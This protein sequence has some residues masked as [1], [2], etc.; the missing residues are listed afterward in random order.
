MRCAIVSPNKTSK[1]VRGCLAA[2][3]T[4]GTLLLC[5]GMALAFSYDDLILLVQAEQKQG[6]SK[7]NLSLDERLRNLETSVFGAAR[8]GSESKRLKDVC[9]QIGL[10]HDAPPP[11]QPNAEEKGPKGIGKPV[12]GSATPQPARVETA[13]PTPVTPPKPP[14][15]KPPARVETPKNVATE[16]P[17]VKPVE[18]PRKPPAPKPPKFE[19]PDNITKPPVNTQPPKVEETPP[20]P[21]VQPQADPQPST[22]TTTETPPQN[23]EPIVPGETGASTSRTGSAAGLV[24]VGLLG[25]IGFLVFGAVGVVVFLFVKEKSKATKEQHKFDS[26]DGNEPTRQPE[27]AKS[28][29]S[30]SVT[31]QITWDESPAEERP[32]AKS[33]EVEEPADESLLSVKN[34]VFKISVA[35]TQ[36]TL[37]PIA[38]GEIDNPLAYQDGAQPEARS[39]EPP[40]SVQPLFE[41]SAGAVSFSDMVDAAKSFN[42]EISTVPPPA[43][44]LDPSP[45]SDAPQYSLQYQTHSDYDHNAA[46]PTP[47]GYG[48]FLNGGSS[49]AEPS[50]AWAQAAFPFSTQPQSEAGT[51]SNA[52]IS[53]ADAARPIE[54]TTDSASQDPLP[55]QSWDLDGNVIYNH[56]MPAEHSSSE[57][58][59]SEAAS[60]P[61]GHWTSGPSLE[62]SGSGVLWKA[63][64]LDQHTPAP[65][66]QIQW[67]A[68]NQTFSEMETALQRTTTGDAEPDHPYVAENNSSENDP[69]LETIQGALPSSVEPWS[70]H[71]GAE[72]QGLVQYDP[73]DMLSEHTQGH[74]ADL[75]PAPSLQG[76][77]SSY[78]DG[79][80]A[81]ESSQEEENAT[82]ENAYGANY[83]LEYINDVTG[84]DTADAPASVSNLQMHS[85]IDG[86][87]SASGDV[88]TAHSNL[89]DELP[90]ESVAQLGTPSGTTEDAEPAA[91]QMSSKND[92]IDPDSV[93]H[94][95]PGAGDSFE[96]A[97]NVPSFEEFQKNRPAS[98]ST[99]GEYGP[100]LSPLPGAMSSVF[101]PF[102][103]EINQT[104]D[105]SSASKMNSQSSNVP[106]E[107]RDF[108][109]QSMRDT[110]RGA[111]DEA[112]HAGEPVAEA[113]AAQAEPPEA[114]VP[115]VPPP[116]QDSL[117][118]ALSK[119]GL[120]PGPQ[121]SKAL[122]DIWSPQTPEQEESEQEQPQQEEPQQEYAQQ[123][124]SNEDESQQ[125]TRPDVSPSLPKSFSQMLAGILADPPGKGTALQDDAAPADDEDAAV[126][127][128][129]YD[130]EQVETAYDAGHDDSAR[131]HA[132]SLQGALNEALTG[133]YGGKKDQEDSVFE[134]LLRTLFADDDYQPELFPNLAKEGAEDN[135][136]SVPPSTPL[137]S[138]IRPSVPAPAVA[139]GAIAFAGQQ[140]MQVAPPPVQ[141]PAAEVDSPLLV[142]SN[143]GQYQN[144]LRNL[145]S[146]VSK[147]DRVRRGEYQAVIYETQPGCLILCVDQSASMKSPLHPGSSACKSDIVAVVINRF[148]HRLI[149]RC[150]QESGKIRASW[151]V[152][153]IGYGETVGPAFIG[154]HQGKE[155]VSVSDLSMT[156]DYVLPDRPKSTIVGIPVW[157]RPK[158]SGQ[159]RMC[160]ALSTALKLARDFV[161]DNPTSHPPIIVN[162]SGGTV[163]DGDP[164]PLAKGIKEI[165]SADGNVLLFNVCLPGKPDEEML[166]FPD[167]PSQLPDHLAAKAMWEMSSPLLLKMI[168]LAREYHI[169]ISPRAR[170]FA[171]N[172]DVNVIAGLLEMCT[173]ET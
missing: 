25:V 153:V 123:K 117:N 2:V 18:R 111:T 95:Q 11:E 97:E 161:A 100:T 169:E 116:A 132:P 10:L 16:E 102:V 104:V 54:Q 130:P 8:A 144:Q 156:V 136:V 143:S 26:T 93:G 41:G 19:M 138:T 145:F 40:L 91:S 90:Q 73:Q 115:Q 77:T 134:R 113:P 86:H 46:D 87:Q 17:P 108:N 63:G 165:A 9:R 164:R 49:P 68:D 168:H 22:E 75:H 23:A 67:S 61:Q 101:G 37:Q 28:N 109:L 110:M 126:Q 158:S 129:G 29:S 107:A 38:A 135:Q 69:Q 5:Q 15:K 7:T 121:P 47:V 66:A 173:A 114:A 44:P 85:T 166:N 76:E 106:A 30:R 58:N 146:E 119:L 118:R 79:G 45:S 27:P 155:L 83:E 84:S 35:G 3:V 103:D 20:N 137:R 89:E 94:L 42:A 39:F 160:G 62:D 148:I 53:W 36:R 154:K 33:E 34:R 162:I 72:D 149:K 167:D 12:K 98:S 55:A 127:H 131:E 99:D 142:R 171:W 170:G 14:V 24:A 74:G 1:S 65:P 112:S 151:Y 122:T 57:A 82:P 128:P 105:F 120:G 70:A 52:P 140:E 21:P 150:K 4:A 96:N 152:G 71:H 32:P 141:N 13:Q 157:V 92:E 159:A 147:D 43:P 56:E 6:I 139:S 50:S 48:E 78:D 133:D 64:D 172:S 59:N 81:S 124:D 31:K 125:N 88:E 60:E 80:Y 163:A 51:V